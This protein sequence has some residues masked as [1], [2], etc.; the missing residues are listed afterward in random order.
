MVDIMGN[1]FF[2]ISQLDHIGEY[3][4]YQPLDHWGILTI[5]WVWKKTHVQG[6]C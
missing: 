4:T 3:D 2:H 1:D 5:L 6:L